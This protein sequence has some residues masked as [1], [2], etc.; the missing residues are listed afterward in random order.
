MND[1]N[2]AIGDIFETFRTDLSGIRVK[3]FLKLVRLVQAAI[4]DLEKSGIKDINI[5]VHDHDIRVSQVKS[6][7]E[8]K[9]GEAVFEVDQT[10]VYDDL[11]HACEGSFIAPSVIQTILAA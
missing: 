11:G 3:K 2:G 4:P 5:H 1:I 6:H 7:W 10:S 9:I 8:V